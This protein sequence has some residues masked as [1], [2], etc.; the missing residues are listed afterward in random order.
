MAVPAR[1]RALA[2]EI[3]RAAAAPDAAGRL[4]GYFEDSNAI[5]AGLGSADVDRVRSYA[6]AALA[7]TAPEAGIGAAREE[8]ETGYSAGPLAAAARVVAALE[9]PDRD[10]LDLLT[11]AAAR[12]RGT[13]RKVWF[14]RIDAAPRPEIVDTATSDLVRAFIAVSDALGLRPADCAAILN[15][16]PPAFSA[17]VRGA[18]SETRP[19]LCCCRHHRSAPEWAAR[20]PLHPEVWGTPAQDQDWRTASLGD[21][22]LGRPAV[23]AFFY[24]RCTNPTKCSRTVATLAAL[25]R[26]AAA[27]GLSGRIAI[28]AITYDPDWDTPA[29]LHRYGTDRGLTFSA[30]TGL[31][32][33]TEGWESARAAFDLAVGY[34]P[35]TVNRHRIEVLMLAPDGRIVFDTAGRPPE[36]EGL[37]TRLIAACTPG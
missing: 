32:R 36:T 25:Q 21:R 4:T 8:I 22:L 3:D 9:R 13:D 24:T 23:L 26:R 11:A 14:D 34:G 30:H 27:K 35:T 12:V 6:L 19:S 20:R 17:A 2:S 29:R 28:F 10:W 33:I 18:L 31:L 5:Y 16:A 15:N 37:L 7:R 1:L